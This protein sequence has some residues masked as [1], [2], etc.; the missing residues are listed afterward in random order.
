[1]FAFPWYAAV[2]E[3][4]SFPL[5]WSQAVPGVQHGSPSQELAAMATPSLLWWEP[6]ELGVSSALLFL[7]R[8][9]CTYAE[10]N[11]VSSG[12]SSHLEASGKVSLSK[13]CLFPV[14]SIL[15]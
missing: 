5:F 11:P 2:V 8:A 14:N 7:R 3:G 4:P 10:Q 9:D 15:P 6:P 12:S 1:M 13:S